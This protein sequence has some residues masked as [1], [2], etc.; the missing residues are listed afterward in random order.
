MLGYLDTNF[1][2]GHKDAQNYLL[3]S[4]I[5]P[6]VHLLEDPSAKKIGIL[7]Q[8]LLGFI[9]TLTDLDFG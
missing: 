8:D 9:L 4:G 1:L 3:Q 6:L 2:Q 5:I 7:A